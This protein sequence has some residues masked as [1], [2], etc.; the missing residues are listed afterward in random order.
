[1]CDLETLSQEE[2][3]KRTRGAIAVRALEERQ[4]RTHASSMQRP[5]RYNRGE[6]E[7]RE[8][9]EKESKRLSVLVEGVD[10]SATTTPADG[11]PDN[12]N[13]LPITAVAEGL[14]PAPV[15]RFPPAPAPKPVRQ[16]I[17]AGKRKA[18]AV[19]APDIEVI[20]LTLSDDDDEDR[21]SEIM[22]AI[23]APFKQASATLAL[24]PTSAPRASQAQQAPQSSLQPSPVRAKRPKAGLWRARP[25]D[26]ASRRWAAP[27][28]QGSGLHGRGCEGEKRAAVE[29]W[30]QFD[31]RTLEVSDDECNGDEDEVR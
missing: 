29:R 7:E 30:R 3:E 27:L 19:P 17:S 25:S 15:S 2:L 14:H 11:V 26:L 31:A 1:M 4:V 21:L 5:S 16:S 23:I 18:K 13:T 9:V 8:D 12:T 22:R 24:A 10:R 20:D 6:D 28:Q